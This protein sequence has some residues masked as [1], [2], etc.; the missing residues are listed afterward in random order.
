M[1]LISEHGGEKLGVRPWMRF[2]AVGVAVTTAAAVG[3][4]AVDADSAW[5]RSLRK[6]GWQPPSWAFG[7][8]WTPLYA[9]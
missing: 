7:V 2:G 5:Y 6:P 1:R 9:A 3:G 4:R 8:V